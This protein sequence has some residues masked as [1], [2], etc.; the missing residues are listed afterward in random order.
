MKIQ[1][2]M[3]VHFDV[4]G[5]C[6][7]PPSIMVSYSKQLKYPS[8]ILPSYPLTSPAKAQQVKDT[9]IEK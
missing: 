9:R 1:D 3:M 8:E 6:P 4:I 7:F 2:W 5:F